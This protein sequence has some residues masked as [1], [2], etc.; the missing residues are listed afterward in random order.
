MLL[1]GGMGNGKWG[2]GTVE[3]ETETFKKKMI[4]VEFSSLIVLHLRAYL[5]STLNEFP[6]YLVLDI[7]WKKSDFK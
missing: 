2:M 1:K 3:W 4:S 7:R 6:R 5:L